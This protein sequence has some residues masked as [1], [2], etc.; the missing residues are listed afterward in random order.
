MP[1]KS[2]KKNCLTCELPKCIHDIEEQHR[3]VRENY[4][5]VRHA[6]YYKAHRD[7]R[8]KKQKEYNEKYRDSVYNHT[9]YL[10]H[11]A[12]INKKHQER[13]ASD[14]EARLQQAKNYY[15]EHREEISERRKLR[16]KEKQIGK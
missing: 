2:C 13:Y 9:Y 12:E 11:K 10:K 6:E 8:I 3:Y 15:W 1:R 14:R 4:D 16:R 7:E 5:K